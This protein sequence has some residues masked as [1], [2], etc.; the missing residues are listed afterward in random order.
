MTQGRRALRQRTKKRLGMQPR[1]YFGGVTSEV[2]CVCRSLVG[3]SESFSCVAVSSP[4]LFLFLIGCSISLSCSFIY[5]S[6]S[7]LLIYP[8]RRGA[9][10]FLVLFFVF[11]IFSFLSFFLHLSDSN[12]LFSHSFFSFHLPHVRLNGKSRCVPMGWEQQ[13]ID[14][15]CSTFNRTDR[16]DRNKW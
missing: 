7:F 4:F 3:E 13:R 2:P 10:T 8:H 11:S 12:A 9:R 15:R 6:V 14:V 5:L 1:A 16:I